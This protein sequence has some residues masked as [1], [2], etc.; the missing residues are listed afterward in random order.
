MQGCKCRS[1]KLWYNK[2]KN[3][4]KKQLHINGTE[5][6]LLK[7]CT[8]TGVRNYYQ[9]S[10]G[11][12]IDV[13]HTPFPTISKIPG[14]SRILPAVTDIRAIRS[15]RHWTAVEWNQVVLSYESRFNRSNDDNRVRVSR[16]LE[17]R[18]NPAFALQQHTAPTA[19]V[20]VWDAIV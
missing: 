14:M 15:S 17:E 11:R 10:S 16:P 20:M 6:I 3:K 19:G 1:C 7:G 5:N 9:K 18:L 2:E 13:L 8:M 12:L 4:N